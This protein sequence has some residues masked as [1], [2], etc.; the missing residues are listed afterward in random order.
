M[1]V[2]SHN[3][4]IVDIDFQFGKWCVCDMSSQTNVT[5]ISSFYRDRHRKM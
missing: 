3:Y 4:N 1:Y 5:E 2:Q